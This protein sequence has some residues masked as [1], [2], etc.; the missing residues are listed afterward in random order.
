M[1]EHDGPYRKR[2]SSAGPVVQGVCEGGNGYNVGRSVGI[3]TNPLTT[4]EHGNAL[5]I[6]ESREDSRKGFAEE[7]T[8]ELSGKE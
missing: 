4:V 8:F 6:P 1:S 7:V 2:H 5:G 3:G